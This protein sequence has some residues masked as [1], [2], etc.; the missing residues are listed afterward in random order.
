MYLNYFNTSYQ[1]GISGSQILLSRPYVGFLVS[2]M[3]LC[4]PNG[5]KKVLSLFIAL[6]HS[7]NNVKLEICKSMSLDLEDTSIMIVWYTQ[8]LWA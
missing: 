1:K 7:L 4:I 8:L 5:K 2:G 6:V 3:V